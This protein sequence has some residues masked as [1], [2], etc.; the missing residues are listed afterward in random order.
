MSPCRFRNRFR[1]EF[2]LKVTF[3]S[4]LLQ[5]WSVIIIAGLMICNDCA[6]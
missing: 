3:V 6:V 5:H 4:A 1:G 2:G